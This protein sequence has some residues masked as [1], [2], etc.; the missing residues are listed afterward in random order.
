ML[1]FNFWKEKTAIC[2]NALKEI[3]KPIWPSSVLEIEIE[4][5]FLG[6][7]LRVYLFLFHKLGTGNPARRLVEI[8]IQSLKIKNGGVEAVKLV[9]EVIIVR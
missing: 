8:K 7:L 9:Y 3:T 4:R 5:L 2:C 1:C 6:V